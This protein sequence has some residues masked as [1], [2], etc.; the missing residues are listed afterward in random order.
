MGRGANTRLNPLEAKARATEVAE[1]EVVVPTEEEAEE[2]AAEAAQ[3]ISLRS[4]SPLTAQLATAMSMGTPSSTHT[5]METRTA[6]PV[7][8]R[9]CLTL[10]GRS[11]RRREAEEID[12]ERFV[13]S[14]SVVVAKNPSINC[15]NE[16]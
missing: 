6:P 14:A 1:T 15:R 8:V 3:A 10:K 13:C 12:G 4:P 7:L 9:K 2:V 11:N 5:L 16:A